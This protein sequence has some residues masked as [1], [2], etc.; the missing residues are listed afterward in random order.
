[1]DNERLENLT[2][3]FYTEVMNRGNL[4]LV[5]ELVDQNFIEHEPTRQA[6]RLAVKGYTSGLWECGQLSPISTQK[7]RI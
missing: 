3:R 6:L 4:N 5:D 2:R 7:S 1:M